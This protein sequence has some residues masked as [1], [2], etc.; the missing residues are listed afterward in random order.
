MTIAPS[1]LAISILLAGLLLIGL[2][3]WLVYRFFGWIGF[4]VACASGVLLVTLWVLSD[5]PKAR[6]AAVRTEIEKIPNIGIT[7]ISDLEK[8]ASESITAHIEVHGK[9]KIGF[10]A[11]EPESFK[12]SRHICLD[13]IGPFGF[14]SRTKVD[15]GQAYAWWVDIGRDSPIPAVRAL[16]LTNVQAAISHYDEILSLVSDWP[17]STHGWPAHWPVKEEEWSQTSKE[18]VHFSDSKG[19][20]YFFCL[21]RSDKEQSAQQK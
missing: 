12:D 9:G 7:G 21:T 4:G 10:T 11:L 14:C 18:E 5:S 15:G 3:A 1:I 16:A 20:D 19:V 6:V 2:L 17:V 13:G 8:Q